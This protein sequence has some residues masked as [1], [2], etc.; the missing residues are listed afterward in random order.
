[1]RRF[2]GAGS[3]L[4]EN[5]DEALSYSPLREKRSIPAICE[6]RHRFLQDIS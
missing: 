5:G 3:S 2:D 6:K 4:Q 1:M